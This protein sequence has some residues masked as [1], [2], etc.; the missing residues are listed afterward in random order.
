MYI[1]NIEPIILGCAIKLCIVCIHVQPEMNT[2]G[3]F[4]GHGMGGGD[5]IASFT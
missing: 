5:T 4:D 3:I 1:V 2:L